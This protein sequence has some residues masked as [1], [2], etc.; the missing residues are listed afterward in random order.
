M[1]LVTTATVARSPNRISPDMAKLTRIA[2]A[3]AFRPL[4]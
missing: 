4:C 2:Q 1:S 3:A